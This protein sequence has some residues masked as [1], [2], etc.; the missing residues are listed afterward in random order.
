MP[1]LLSQLTPVINMALSWPTAVHHKFRGTYKGSV[2]Y[3]Q[4][5]PHCYFC[6]SNE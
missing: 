3:K 6:L 1:Q 2:P 5:S 4:P